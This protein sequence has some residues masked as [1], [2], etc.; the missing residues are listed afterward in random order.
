M[1]LF[2]KI[3]RILGW[4]YPARL[5]L[6]SW[7][8]RSAGVAVP[9]ARIAGRHDAT[10]VVSRLT[11][12]RGWVG[13]TGVR[14]FSAKANRDSPQPDRPAGRPRYSAGAGTGNKHPA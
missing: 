2:R 11:T 13:S 3:R 12:S 14:Q 6:S 1:S 7:V 10:S 9:I 5:T 8:T 4:V